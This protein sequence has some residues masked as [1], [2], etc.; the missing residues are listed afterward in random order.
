MDVFEKKM[1][2]Y[3]ETFIKINSLNQINNIQEN[4]ELLNLKKNKFGIKNIKIPEDNI[5][6]IQNE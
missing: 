3:A 6:Q 5:E 2:K 1:E 4:S